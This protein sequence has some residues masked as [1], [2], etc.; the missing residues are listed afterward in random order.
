MV[1]TEETEEN[2]GSVRAK[3]PDTHLDAPAS[4]SGDPRSHFSSDE[5]YDTWCAT[6]NRQCQRDPKLV[7]DEVSG[8]AAC[9][10]ADTD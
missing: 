1:P 3:T 8:I 9:L 5:A 7:G 4:K 10:P 2:E 6:R